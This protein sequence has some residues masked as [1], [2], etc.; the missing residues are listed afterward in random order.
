MCQGCGVTATLE[1]VGV[2]RLA[3]GRWV[4]SARAAGLQ[5]IGL[6][7]DG[8]VRGRSREWRVGVM[9]GLMA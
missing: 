6:V 3:A 8:Q 7:G 2:G 9:C 1:S 5:G 4:G